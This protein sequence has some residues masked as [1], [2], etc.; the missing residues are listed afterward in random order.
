MRSRYKQQGFW[1][2]CSFSIASQE[3]TLALTFLKAFVFEATRNN[4]STKGKL[5]LV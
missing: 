1:L 5:R 2:S 3:F 4:S